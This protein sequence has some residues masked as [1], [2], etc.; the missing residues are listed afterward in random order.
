[1]AKQQK[2]GWVDI[3]G[4]EYKTVALR[5]SEFWKEREAKQWRILTRIQHIDDDSCRMEAT[6]YYRADEDKEWSEVANGHSSKRRIDGPVNRTSLV[7]NCETHAIGRALATFGLG[8]DEFASADEVLAVLSQED[9]RPR[10]VDSHGQKEPGP[11]QQ[12]S[13]SQPPASEGPVT[14]AFK[15]PNPKWAKIGQGGSRAQ[16]EKALELLIHVENAINNAAESAAYAKTVWAAKDAGVITPTAY[17]IILDAMRDCYRH[18]DGN[19]G[20]ECWWC[21]RA[22]LAGVEESD[23]IPF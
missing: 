16:Q 17:A 8:G 18:F 11:V 3:R 20:S 12:P 9:E 2:K 22:A 19:C 23:E 10:G 13:P 5:V 1:M 6:V 21:E 15:H 14:V 4:K 7:E